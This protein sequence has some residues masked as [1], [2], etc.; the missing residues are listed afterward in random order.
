[1]GVMFFNVPCFF[2]T[3]SRMSIITLAVALNEEV[4]T[5]DQIKIIFI[6][7][8]VAFFANDVII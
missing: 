7:K 6:I 2:F 3:V 5:D 8:H 4:D 1:M